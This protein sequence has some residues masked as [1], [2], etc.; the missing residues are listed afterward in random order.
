LSKSEF[1]TI[2]CRFGAFLEIA[3]ETG[4]WLT[5][6]C[7]R[8]AQTKVVLNS[9]PVSHREKLDLVAFVPE[10][11]LREREIPKLSDL[12]Q[13]LITKQTVKNTLQ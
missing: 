5:S 6:R 4:A 13:G 9:L 11:V 10:F 7:A 12:F 8:G 2:R 1:L 3:Q